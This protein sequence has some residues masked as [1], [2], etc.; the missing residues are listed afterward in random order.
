[1]AIITN[2]KKILFLRN[3]VL[4]SLG[5]IT[6]SYILSLLAVLLVHGAF[7][8]NM[9]EWGTPLSQTLM[10]I[11]GGI[12]IGLGTGIYQKS[13]LEKM[14]N[15][16]SSWIYTLIGGFVLTELISGTVLWQMGLNRAELRFIEFNPLPESLIFACIGLLT[17]LF[18]WPLLRQYFNRSGYW[19]VA[20]ALG[21]G[22]CILINVLSVIA[23][24]RNSLIA[25]ILVFA[26]GAL[27]YGALTGATLIWIMKLKDYQK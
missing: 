10:Q 22:F 26:S 6:L 4:L 17:G 13:L 9:T 3:W 21:W 5:V 16:K 18:Q 23:F 7:G 14:F 24:N 25:E 2:K 12:V 20:S 1:M 8:F 19:I 11:A 27:L 15:V